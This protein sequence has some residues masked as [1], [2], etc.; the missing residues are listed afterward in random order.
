M[1]HMSNEQPATVRTPTAG[2]LALVATTDITGYTLVN[3]TG[4]ILSWQ[5]PNDGQMHRVLVF[6]TVNITSA[7]TGGGIQ[8]A[9]SPPGTGS[10]LNTVDAG[11]HGAGVTYAPP[12]ELIAGPN[13]T[14]VVNQSSALT[15]GAAVAFIEV[16]GS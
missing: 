12:A 10:H 4:Q 16:W 2:P 11:G 15:V 9:S 13:T 6:C 1:T 14:V 8:A 7:E 5:T 3:G